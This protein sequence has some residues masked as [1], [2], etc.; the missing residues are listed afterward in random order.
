MLILPCLAGYCSSTRRT[1]STRTSTRA[2]TR[3]STR[4]SETSKYNRQGEIGDQYQWNSPILFFILFLFSILSP[5]SVAQ[6]S[7]SAHPCLAGDCADPCLAGYCA[8]R[9]FF[10]ALFLISFPFFRFSFAHQG[11]RLKECGT[12]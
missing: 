7:H 3:T 2:S 4:T 1:T 12:Y 5:P 6:S 9:S 10:F 8:P 11:R